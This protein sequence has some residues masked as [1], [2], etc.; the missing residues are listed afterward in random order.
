M[1]GFPYRLLE[2]AIVEAVFGPG[3]AARAAAR[4][5]DRVQRRAVR[6]TY[7]LWRGFDAPKLDSLG[8]PSRRWWRPVEWGTDDD[9]TRWPLD[10]PERMPERVAAGTAYPVPACGSADKPMNG[11]L[12]RA[13]KHPCGKRAG[14]RTGHYGAGACWRHR[15]NTRTGRVRGALIMAHAFARELDCS[16][17]EGLLRAVRIA[18]GKLG[19]CE[20]VLSQASSDLELEGRFGRSEDGIL[21]H[22]DTGDPLGGGQ[23]RDL[24]WWVQKSELW[25]DRLARYSKMAIDAGV[26]ERLVHQVEVEGQSMGRVLSAALGELEGRVSEDLLGEVRAAMRREL[27]QIESEQDNAR[28]RAT[29]DADAGVV[30]STYVDEE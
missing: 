6:E 29:R 10:D 27:L 4:S 19:Y 28:V 20:W 18:A 30:D 14:E 3:E 24:S 25:T 22:P 5:L 12:A 15:G 8:R 2:P 1:T 9:G 23:V 16:P 17:W 26:A 21:L 13:S 7:L 11:R